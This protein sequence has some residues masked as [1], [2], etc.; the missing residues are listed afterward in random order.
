MYSAKN[1]GDVNMA[2]C[3]YFGLFDFWHRSGLGLAW[4]LGING[5]TGKGRERYLAKNAFMLLNYYL[6]I[7]S[8]FCS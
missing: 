6:S 2:T 1:L 8:F 7:I 3:K 5:Y 4:F